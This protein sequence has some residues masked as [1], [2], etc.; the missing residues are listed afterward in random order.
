MTNS[1]TLQPIFR[2]Y[3]REKKEIKRFTICIYYSSITL[4]ELR[5]NLSFIK[6]SCFEKKEKEKVSA[7]NKKKRRRWNDTIY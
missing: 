1:T 5:F 3:E 7:N 4:L 6:L 2:N